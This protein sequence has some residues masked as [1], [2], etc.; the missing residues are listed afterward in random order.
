MLGKWRYWLIILLLIGAVIGGV[1]VLHRTVTLVIDGQTRRVTAWMLTAGSVLH[2]VGIPLGPADRLTPAVGAW[3]TFS[4]LVKIERAA[5]VS[6]LADGKSTGLLSP[7]R[8]PVKLLALAGIQLGASDLLLSDG[9]AIQP[10][11]LLP[12][13]ASHTLQVRRSVTVTLVMDGQTSSFQSTAVTLGEALWQAGIRLDPDDSLVPGFETPLDKSIQA[14]IRHA[15]PLTIS[16]QGQEI[17][18][19]SSAP[20]VGL[21]LAQ[22]GLSLQG[23]DYSQPAEDQPVPA[24]G[25]IRLVRV[26]EEVLLTQKTIPFDI[27]TVADPNTELDA[28]SVIQP[29]QEGIIVTRTRVRYE[30]GKEVNRQTEGEWQARPPQERIL[31]YGTK[32]VIHTAVVDGVKIQYWRAV[33]MFATSY[34]PCNSDAD[35]C[36]PHTATGLPVVKGVAGVKRVWFDWMNGQNVFVPGYGS[37]VIADFGGGY[38]DGRAHIDLGFSDA[39]YVPW[40]SWVTVYFLTPV[41]EN[42]LWILQ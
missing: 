31:G 21:A 2:E 36:Y 22:V 38:P 11:M 23:L 15:V 24:D 3:I 19:R 18:A 4:P 17:K 26:R 33:T 1:L 6:I 7:E 25:R 12:I 32:V 14:T 41:P 5:Q 16:L 10:D 29:G 20:T 42:I 37:A 40:A 8:N 28:H 30:D 13:S 9:A 35:H 39:D 34:S 27:K